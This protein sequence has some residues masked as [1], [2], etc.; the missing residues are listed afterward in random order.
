[1]QIC[2]KNKEASCVTR[3]MYVTQCYKRHIEIPSQQSGNF[4]MIRTFATKILFRSNVL[5]QYSTCP[6]NIISCNLIWTSLRILNYKFVAI[7]VYTNTS[8]HTL[9][10]RTNYMYQLAF[11]LY[12]RQAISGYIHYVTQGSIIYRLYKYDC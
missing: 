4:N 3:D 9:P 7:S 12:P 10:C 5:S 6:P 8:H 2:Y 11:Q 1:M